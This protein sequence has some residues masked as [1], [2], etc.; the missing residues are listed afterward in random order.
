[1]KLLTARLALL[2]GATIAALCMAEAAVRIIAAMPWRKRMPPELSSA[3]AV[4]EALLQRL[5][6]SVESDRSAFAAF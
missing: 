3:W 2:L 1:M 4:T 5:R 6:D